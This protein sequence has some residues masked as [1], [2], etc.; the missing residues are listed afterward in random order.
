M[1]EIVLLD[2][3]GDWY[4]IY[5]LML[6][7]SKTKVER[8]ELSTKMSYIDLQDADLID[9]NNDMF[10]ANLSKILEDTPDEKI[11]GQNVLSQAKKGLIAGD[12]LLQLFQM[13]NFKVKKPSLRKARY[14]VK[15]MG[16][17]VSFKDGTTFVR[18]DST[19]KKYWSEFSS[20]IHLWAA[21]RMNQQHSYVPNGKLFT[22]PNGLH[23]FMR[24]AA[25]LQDF[26]T[27]YIPIGSKG[28]TALN[29]E[30]CLKIPANIEPATPEGG[31]APKKL[32]KVIDG[33]KYYK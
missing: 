26:G 23:A 22:E 33:Y 32:L 16:D 29:Y 17:N 21:I 19:I 2:D 1:S 9:R 7:P 10:M 5:T 4:R 12:V 18:D 24:V 27:S 25:L 30:T 11:L 8:D 20:V 15:T 31:A 28:K 6:F 13:D 3:G 14:I